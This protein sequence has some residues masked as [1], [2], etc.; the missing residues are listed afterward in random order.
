MARP[1]QKE[2]IDLSIVIVSWNTRKLLEDCLHSVY[3]GLRTVRNEIWV[4]DNASSDGSVEFIRKNWP[5]VR[6]IANS[7]NVGFARANNQAIPLASGR[8]VLLLNSDTL[9]PEG[10]LDALVEAMDAEPEA[11]VCSPM[12]LN[13]D[14]TPQYCW[15]RFPGLASELS[16]S[17][18]LAQ[19][20]YPVSDFADVTKRTA[21]Q[22]FFVDWVGGACFMVRASLLPQVGLLDEGYFMYSEETDWCV[23]FRALGKKVMLVPAVTVTHLG[24]GSSRAVPW[25]TRERMYRSSLRFYRKT[26]GPLGAVLPS[27]FSSLRYALFRLVKQRESYAKQDN[28]AEERGS[29]T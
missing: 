22:P 2:T 26:Y 7:E 13:L 1:V 15:A 9:V 23:R 5:H 8:Y 25:K 19:S 21:M 4:V 29:G 6:L 10:V 12:L 20:P 11:A 18:D 17:L 16:G 3:A 14:G 28:R 24:G 27:A